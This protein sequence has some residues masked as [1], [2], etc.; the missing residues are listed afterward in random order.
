MPSIPYRP[1]DRQDA[2]TLHDPLPVRGIAA[3]IGILLG[4]FLSVM[5][6]RKV[7]A[8]GGE[9]DDAAR[10][11]RGR[12]WSFR[13]LSSPV[14]RIPGVA[15]WVRK[16]IDAFVL[17]RP[18]QRGL[19][20]APTA[21]RPVQEL[22][23]LRDPEPGLLEMAGTAM[24]TPGRSRMIRA[25]FGSRRLSTKQPIDSAGCNGFAARTPLT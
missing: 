12:H 3:P 15:A 2:P 10:A 4:L 18:E 23:W 22:G 17:M 1:A 7:R 24:Q 25:I 8:G 21:G 9:E 13:T 11:G 5:I 16:P 6:A 14:P 19:G 20:P